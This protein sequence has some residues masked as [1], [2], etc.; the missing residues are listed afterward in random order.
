MSEATILNEFCL[1]KSYGLQHE[2]IWPSFI[3][4]Q[5]VN[6]TFWMNNTGIGHI[7]VN[8]FI[9]KH[10]EALGANN[11]NVDLKV[12]RIWEVWNESWQSVMALLYGWDWEQ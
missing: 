4:K 6:F 5:L 1:L 7:N 9:R 2:L 12:D 10:Q 3:I 8:N 11:I